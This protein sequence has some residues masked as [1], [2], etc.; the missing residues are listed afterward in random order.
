MVCGRFSNNPMFWALWHVSRQS[1]PGPHSVLSGKL[2]LTHFGMQLALGGFN[3]PHRLEWYGWLASGSPASLQTKI[4]LTAFATY[5][6]AW[7]KHRSCWPHCWVASNFV[8]VCLVKGKPTFRCSLQFVAWIIHIGWHVGS[9]L[10][11]G[12]RY[13]QVTLCQVHKAANCR[14]STPA[15]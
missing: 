7:C 13:M 6:G 10:R 9:A 5:Q 3:R 12:K 4:D 11:V 14:H 2:V 8:S 1:S 15:P